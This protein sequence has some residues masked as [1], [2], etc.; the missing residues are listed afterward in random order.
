MVDV[1]QVSISL[2]CSNNKFHLVLVQQSD[3]EIGYDSMDVSENVDDLCLLN[4]SNF[5][6][7][8]TNNTNNMCFQDPDEDVIPGSFDMSPSETTANESSSRLVI[9]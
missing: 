7:V 6:L 4:V 1:K 3:Q 5:M 9:F 2:K 8:G